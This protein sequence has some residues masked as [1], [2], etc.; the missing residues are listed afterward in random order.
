MTSRYSQ[1]KIELY[2][3]FRVLRAYRIWLVGLKKFTVEV[4]AKYIR[5]M[6]NN[7]DIVPNAAM[8]RWIAGILLFDFDLI[9][10]PADRHKVADGLSRR[11]LA[12]E[13]EV[14]EDDSEDWIDQAYGFAV[15]VLNWSKLPRG[16]GST[17]SGR[18][19]KVTRCQDT[20]TQLILTT[21]E[22]TITIPRS[23]KARKRDKDVTRI[24]EFLG[25]PR[26]KE[27]MEEKEFQ[28]LVKRAGGYFVMDQKL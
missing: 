22:A 28:R 25:D 23:E 21:E 7:P 12:P 2:G 10:V 20:E 4:D 6:I 18:H 15:E 17:V 27:G 9:H 3:L 19:P 14:E 26:R 1:A 13:D 11:P 5:G 16:F 8:N 24:R